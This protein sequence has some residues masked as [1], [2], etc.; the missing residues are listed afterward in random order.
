M[1]ASGAADNHDMREE[2]QIRWKTNAWASRTAV[3][4]YARRIADGSGHGLLKN[5]VEVR[6]FP[7]H[8]RGTDVL[9]VGIGTGRASLPLARTG[10]RV[11][12]IDSSAEMLHAC[13]RQAGDT[14]IDL[15]QGDI[16]SLPFGAQRFD[17]I[18]SLNAFAHFPHWR[19][20][21][22]N[23]RSALRPGGRMIFDVFSLDHDVAYAR[24]IGRDDAYG[25]DA[26]APAGAEAYRLRLRVEELAD[27]ASDIGLRV[28][29]VIPYGLFCGVAGN[30]RFFS[31]TNVEGFSWYRF[32]SWAAA[33]EPFHDFMLFLEEQIVG[34]LTSAATWRYMVVLEAATDAPDANGRWR[35]R[36]RE[37]NRAL[38]GGLTA[39]ALE[40]YGDADLSSLRSAFDAHLEHEPNLFAL[41]RILLAGADWRWPLRLSDFINEKHRITLERMLY[42]GLLDRTAFDAARALQRVPELAQPLAYRGVPLGE[43]IAYDLIAPLLDGCLHA[44]DASFAAGATS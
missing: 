34:R 3:E 8:A 16:A 21:L 15:V 41:A 18:V 37:Y 11:T 40:T 14:P 19:R 39:A 26:F 13:R 9:D 31:K 43:A 33:D 10:Y 25:I 38:Q 35:A 42:L 44:F 29:G 2:E 23:W 30:N 22:K 12:G 32:L 28:V 27:F 17:T 1:P 6:M 24:A 7:R 20:I 5:E 36:N 4:S